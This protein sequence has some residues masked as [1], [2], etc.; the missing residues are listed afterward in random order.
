[1]KMNTKPKMQDVITPEVKSYVNAYL[2]ARAFAET[3]RAKVDA[4]H[5]EILTQCPIYAD[6]HGHTQQIFES[7]DLY[8]CSNDALC[9]EFYEEADK[10]LRSAKL[11]PDD[12]P[13][14]HCPALVAEYLQTKCEWALIETAGK[15]FGITNNGL[16]ASK[17]GLKNRQQFIDLTVRLIVST[18]GFKNPLTGKAA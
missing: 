17:D 3:M 5:R 16:L 12:M 4:I 10:R 2:M 9:Q 15:P 7:K 13:V 11:K 1:M 14:T 18:P 8:L 6:V